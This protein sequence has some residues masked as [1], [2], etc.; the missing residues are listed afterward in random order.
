MR[1]FGAYFF[2]N[3]ARLQAASGRCAT[4]CATENARKKTTGTEQQSH[5]FKQLCIVVLQLAAFLLLWC[6]V[7]VQYVA[8]KITVTRSTLHATLQR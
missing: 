5:S 3:Y 7:V 4:E 1:A 8:A 6:S 2:S